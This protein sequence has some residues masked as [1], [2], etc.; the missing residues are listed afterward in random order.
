V[1][2]REFAAEVG[3]V[4]RVGELERIAYVSEISFSVSLWNTPVAYA[5]FCLDSSGLRYIEYLEFYGSA[6]FCY[7]YIK[8]AHLAFRPYDKE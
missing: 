3:G 2:R 7:S 1:G 4:Q 5:V 6:S 8:Y